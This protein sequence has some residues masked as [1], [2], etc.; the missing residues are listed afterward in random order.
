MRSHELELTVAV[1]TKSLTIPIDSRH[2]ISCGICVL[3]KHSKGRA[4]LDQ[5]ELLRCLSG[6]SAEAGLV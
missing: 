2:C 3:S 1:L 6:L 5:E 4:R